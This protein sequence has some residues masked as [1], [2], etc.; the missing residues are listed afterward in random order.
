MEST[1]VLPLN[2]FFFFTFTQIFLEI[3]VTCISRC[4]CNVVEYLMT[5]LI[6]VS[7]SK[8]SHLLYHSHHH[9]IPGSNIRD[10][11]SHDQQKTDENDNFVF[12]CSVC[13]I[14]LK[15]RSLKA[16]STL[17]VTVLHAYDQYKLLAYHHCL[18]PE[19]DGN[20]VGQ[21]HKFEFKSQICFFFLSFDY[22]NEILEL[23]LFQID[24]L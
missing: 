9:E 12:S 7:Q 23:N 8:H 1:S 2:T 17:V 22:F 19:R 18:F 11:S 5:F 21:I 10:I 16:F 13:I 4:N 20:R 6:N 24:L 15:L 14:Q 3:F